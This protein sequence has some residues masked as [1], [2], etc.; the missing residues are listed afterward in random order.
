MYVSSRSAKYFNSRPS[1]RGDQSRRLAYPTWIYFNSR[2]SAR[3]DPDCRPRLC[4]WNISIHAPPRGATEILLALRLSNGLFQF[5]PLREG[6]QRPCGTRADESYFN[7]RPSARG[8]T[9]KQRRASAA[10]TFQFT[11]LR[12]GRRTPTAGS[13]GGRYFNSRPSA[14]GD[15]ATSTVK[16]DGS[17]NFNS[18]PSAR[19]DPDSHGGIGRGAVFQFTPLREGRPGSCVP[20]RLSGAFQFTPLREGRLTAEIRDGIA[21]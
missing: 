21:D 14:R 17:S 9:D 18:R 13:A 3:G 10:T 7:S 5:T 11:P 12:E 20:P 19:G 4:V 8:D 2:P 15:P 6:R 1:A 16:P